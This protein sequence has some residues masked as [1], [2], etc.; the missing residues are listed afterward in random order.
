MAATTMNMPSH[1]HNGT[2]FYPSLDAYNSA[3]YEYTRKQFEE[4]EREARLRSERRQT[5]GSKARIPTPG[6]R[7]A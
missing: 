2:V 5:S 3:L 4:A 7:S 1:I 6:R